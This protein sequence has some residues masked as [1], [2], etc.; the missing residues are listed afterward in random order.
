MGKWGQTP[1]FLWVSTKK[2]MGSDPISLQR[3]FRHGLLAAENAENAETVL[4][5]EFSAISSLSAVNVGQLRTDS[6]AEPQRI[7]DNV[8]VPPQ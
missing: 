8:G 4:Y 2:K 7:V 6:S 1:F 3:H 5:K